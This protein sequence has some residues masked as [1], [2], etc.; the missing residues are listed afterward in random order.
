MKIKGLDQAINRLK[1]LEKNAQELDGT[2]S[3]P[4]SQLLTPRFMQRYTNFPTFDA[5][6]EASG[7]RA[8]T[9]AEFDAI[10]DDK[11]DAFIASRTRFSDWQS[12]LSEA[13]KE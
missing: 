3:L 12:M 10:S 9:Q 2:H 11:W 7:F 5:M 4:A 1:D 6:L 13:A 8:E